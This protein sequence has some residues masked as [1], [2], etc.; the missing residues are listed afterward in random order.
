MVK[1]SALANDRSWRA[2]AAHDTVPRRVFLIIEM[3]AEKA[4]SLEQQEDGRVEYPVDPVHSR[5]HLETAIQHALFCQKATRQSE[6]GIGAA[7]AMT[8]ATFSKAC[9]ACFALFSSVKRS[10]PRCCC[11]WHTLLAGLRTPHQFTQLH[12]GHMSHLT[13]RIVAC[14]SKAW[15]LPDVVSPGA[16]GIEALLY[17]L[18]GVTR[19]GTE[20]C[21]QLAAHD[22]QPHSHIDKA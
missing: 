8:S 4:A 22:S 21:P 16:G 12:F 14:L 3:T 5:P 15:S 2:A 9:I 6:S 1:Y 17:P 20:L 13:A 11:S 7:L 18:P 10:L 19:G